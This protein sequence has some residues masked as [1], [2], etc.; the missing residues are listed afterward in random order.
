MHLVT[1]CW[2]T[3]Y[4]E[5]EFSAAGTRDA[6]AAV[7]LV[8]TAQSGY[9]QCDLVMWHTVALTRAAPGWPVMPVEY[10]AFTD[11]RGLL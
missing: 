9:C 7:Y 1:S 5:G 2:A 4:A 3:P 6:M 8:H 10:P 11:P